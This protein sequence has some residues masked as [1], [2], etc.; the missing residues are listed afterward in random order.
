MKHKYA[1]LPK[2]WELGGFSHALR[3]LR[4]LI[5]QGDAEAKIMFRHAPTRFTQHTRAMVAVARAALRVYKRRPTYQYVYPEHKGYRYGK[6]E[7]I[8]E[9]AKEY[10]PRMTDAGMKVPD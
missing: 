8:I 3:I 10:A 5:K 2:S 9:M 6:K 4:A 7:M 1:P